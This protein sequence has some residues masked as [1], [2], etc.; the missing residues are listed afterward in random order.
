VGD[1]SEVSSD[2]AS[3]QTPVIEESQ[4][5]K[6]RGRIMAGSYSSTSPYNTHHRMAYT[7]SLQGS[8]LRNSRLSVD[9]YVSFRHTINDWAEVRDHPGRALKVYSLAVQ[10]DI[11]RSSSISLG[12]KINPHIASMGAIDGV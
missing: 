10:Y 7:F 5:Q 12:R 2:V 8:H 9:S 1:A 6:I 4:E 3:L 11:D